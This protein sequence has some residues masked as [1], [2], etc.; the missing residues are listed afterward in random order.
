[1]TRK[2]LTDRLVGGLTSP[3]DG[4]SIVRD[5]KVKGFGIRVLPSGTR[6]FILDYSSGGRR[7]IYTIGKF[8][9]WTTKAARAHASELK[10]QIRYDGFD[11]SGELKAGREAPNV[12]DLCHRFHKDH[13][14]KLRP[15]TRRDYE[16]MIDKDIIPHL[17]NRKV[18]DIK[19]ADIDR[20]HRKIT[21]RGSPVAAN[22]CIALCSKL[23]S[24]AVRLRMT[25][26]NP[27]KGIERNPAQPR[28]RYL[29]KTEITSLTKALAVYG[30]QDVADIFR[31]LLLTGAR[32]GETQSARWDQFD[33][34]EGMWVKP[35]HATKQGRE[36]R[37]PLAA[38]ARA[39]LAKRREEAVA[40]SKKLVRAV[41][42]AEPSS[43]KALEEWRRRIETFVFPSREGAQGHIVEIKKAWD[44]LCKVAGIVTREELID[45]ETGGARVIE[46]HSARIHD[47]RHTA[48]SILASSGASLPLIGQLLGHT[49][50]A[51]TQRYAHLFDDAQRAAVERLGAAVGGG[52][53]AE[54][55]DLKG[56]RRR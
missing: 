29:G 34:R 53:S 31:L 7:R 23:F 54:I 16:R 18:A 43:R 49:Q 3:T 28:S 45:V 38:P 40:E 9:E 51:T 11:P 39:L 1:M 44:S 6:A 42:K 52:P 4:M 47:L 50:V 36:H 8:P 15:S 25:D 55:I 32:R 56:K 27:V 26:A 2:L 19:F 30:D 24:F 33:L 17:G 35:S 13:M 21:E 46:R 22:F 20:L 37:V 14:P 12:T 5:S 10:H 48:A 41:A